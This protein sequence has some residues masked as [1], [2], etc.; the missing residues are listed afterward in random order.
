MTEPSADLL[1]LWDR[2]PD[3]HCKGLCASACG[4]VD[5]NPEERRLLRERGSA[6]ARTSP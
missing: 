6:F 5:A 3:S 4:P 1:A 2:I